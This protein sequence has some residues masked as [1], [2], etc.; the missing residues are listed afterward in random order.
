MAKVE[1]ETTYAGMPS[2]THTLIDA[3]RFELNP[4]V[5]IKHKSWCLRRNLSV[6][7]VASYTDLDCPWWTVAWTRRSGGADVIDVVIR[8]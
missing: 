5:H 7:F 3:P 4:N 8:S 2:T 1:V 6:G